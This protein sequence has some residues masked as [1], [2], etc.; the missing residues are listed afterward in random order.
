MSNAYNA[1]NVIAKI[2]ITEGQKFKLWGHTRE[3]INQHG[4][5]TEKN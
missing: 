5:K 2:P 4:V 1:L 3:I